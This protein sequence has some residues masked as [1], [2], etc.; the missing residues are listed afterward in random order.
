[1]LTPNDWRRTLHA[2]PLLILASRY[3]A[4]FLASRPAR[5]LVLAWLPSSLLSTKTSAADCCESQHFDW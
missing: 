5:L 2:Q 4:S 1:M 3:P